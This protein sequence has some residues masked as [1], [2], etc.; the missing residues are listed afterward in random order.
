VGYETTIEFASYL[1]YEMRRREMN[2]ATAT[3]S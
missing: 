1:K 2:D 3:H